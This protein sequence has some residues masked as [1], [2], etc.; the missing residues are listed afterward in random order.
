MCTFDLIHKFGCW[1][2]LEF[3]LMRVAKAHHEA[4]HLNFQIGVGVQKLEEVKMKILYLFKRSHRVC[5]LY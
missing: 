3:R 2:E 1:I 5:Q 4:C